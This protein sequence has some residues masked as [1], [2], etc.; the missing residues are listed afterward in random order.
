MTSRFAP[1]NEELGRSLPGFA[2]HRPAVRQ[3]QFQGG[4]LPANGLR[5]FALDPVL[6]AAPA[7]AHR[8]AY[9]FNQQPAPIAQMIDP[10]DPLRAARPQNEQILRHLAAND[11]NQRA[12]NPYEHVWPAPTREQALAQQTNHPIAHAPVQPQR[13]A[14]NSLAV[15]QRGASSSSHITVHPLR[16][17]ANIGENIEAIR[18][19]P[20]RPAAQI[21]DN[22]QAIIQQ[23]PRRL[24]SYLLPW[25]LLILH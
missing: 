22:L 21:N 19:Q 1:G 16:V 4:I 18:Q 10:N 25:S 7:H 8:L 9:A 24:I 15:D 17:A 20:S 6:T 14:T 5:R 11:L 12:Q 3:Q 2:N 13:T 23:A